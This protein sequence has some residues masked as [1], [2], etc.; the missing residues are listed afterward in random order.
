[1][2]NNLDTEFI[3]ACRDNNFHIMK[4]LLDIPKESNVW[5]LAGAQPSK[6]GHLEMLKFL[7]EHREYDDHYKNLFLTLACCNNQLLIVQYL[8]NNFQIDLNYEKSPPLSYA[9][10]YGCLEVVKYLLTSPQTKSRVNIGLQRHRAFRNAVKSFSPN[11]LEI[12]DFLL[13]SPHINQHSNP[14]V[15]DEF[16]STKGN[17][18]SGIKLYDNSH[19]EVLHYLIYEFEVTEDILTYCYEDVIPT[20]EHL[21]NKK[22]LNDKLNNLPTHWVGKKR[23]KV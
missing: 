19:I 18:T 12:I 5:Y 6:Y 22:H 7:L 1:M 8:V 16:V 14:Y 17:V 9:C 10:E 11:K 2:N 13:T 3:H 4:K 23:T 21:F 15:Y 20:V